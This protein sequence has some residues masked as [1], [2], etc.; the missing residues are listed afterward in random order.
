MTA[1]SGGAPVNDPQPWWLTWPV[2]E[3][4]A[5]IL[6]LFAAAPYLGEE[7]GMKGIV[8]WFKTGTYRAPSMYRQQA[9]PR[10]EDPDIRAVAEAI[11]VLEHA[12]LLMRADQGDHE[13][14]LGLTRLGRHAL[15]TN[16]VRQHLGLGDGPPSS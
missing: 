5:A 12:L 13:S 11:Q 8:A 1:G 3:V 4:A 15:Q 14:V 16:T 9:R 6:P 10:F 7:T 2:A